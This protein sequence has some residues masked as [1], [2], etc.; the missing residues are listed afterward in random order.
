M[1]ETDSIKIG[2]LRQRVSIEEPLR[3]GDGGGGA[4][5]SWVELAQ[6]WAQIRPLNGSERAEADGIAGKVS[7]EIVMRFRADIAPEHR[8]FYDGRIFDIRAVLDLDERRRFLR[9]LV[10]ERDL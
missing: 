7:H 8:L 9:C 5:E 3:T 1:T 2:N 4:Q 10:E 6:V